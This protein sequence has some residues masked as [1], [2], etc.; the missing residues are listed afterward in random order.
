MLNWI[1]SP[2]CRLVSACRNDVSTSGSGLTLLVVLT[3][4][5]AAWVTAQNRASVAVK[6]SNVSFCIRQSCLR[7]RFIPCLGWSD[8]FELG[9][10]AAPARRGRHLAD[11]LNTIPH[12]LVYLDPLKLAE[13]RRL[14]PAAPEPGALP[15]LSGP[16]F[17]QNGT[18][19]QREMRVITHR[20][21]LSSRMG[22]G[23]C[24]P[25][26]LSLVY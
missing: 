18:G 13:R 10:A 17:S 21:W 5:T 22:R 2:S 8:S 11:H 24:R 12:P 25:R 7:W 3:V 6:K 16:P 1:V 23:R 26:V 20:S 4:M 15:Q 19:R 14:R 9:S